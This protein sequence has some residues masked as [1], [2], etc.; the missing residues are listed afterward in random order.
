MSLDV[1]WPLQ[2]WWCRGA[3]SCS[4]AAPV[5][6]RTCPPVGQNRGDQYLEATQWTQR[7]AV[8]GAAR[9]MR[10][11]RVLCSCPQAHTRSSTTSQAAYK[12]SMDR[13]L[14]L[15]TDRGFRAATMLGDAWTT[16]DL[17]RSPS[18]GIVG[19]LT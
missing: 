7:K 12:T 6:C 10:D 11:K 15:T 9:V 17:H 8:T 14:S 13:I 3:L 18:E 19:S 5:Y 2:P 16:C 4:L 1:A